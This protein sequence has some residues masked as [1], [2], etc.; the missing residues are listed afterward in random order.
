M[1]F[2]TTSTYDGVS[3][4]TS[5]QDEN[6]LITSF[7][8]RSYANVMYQKTD[9]MNFVITSSYDALFRNTGTMNPQGNS[10]T[11][12]Y[13]NPGLRTGVPNEVG[14]EQ[15]SSFNAVKL[16]QYYE[17][18]NGNITTNT[19]DG[20]RNWLTSQYSNGQI[21]TLQYDPPNRLTTAT[22][23]GGQ[24]TFAYSA[25]SELIGKTD[26]GSLSQSYRYDGVSNCAFRR[27]RSRFHSKAFRFPLESDQV[28]APKRS[29]FQG[30]SPRF[31]CRHPGAYS[32]LRDA[33]V[34]E[35]S[36]ALDHG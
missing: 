28:S 24:T 21:L 35:V 4:L 16:L 23:W 32:K 6:G 22:D 29:R 14:F 20:A 26:P 15:V 33:H 18:G 31:K 10:V 1:N 3:N 11:F 5:I 27:K 25:R 36:D 8:F 34:C 13:N 17:P 7:A 12:T 19:Y 9:P 30:P 2:L